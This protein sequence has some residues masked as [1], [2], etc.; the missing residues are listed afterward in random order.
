MT[1]LFAAAAQEGDGVNVLPIAVLLI[2][3]AVGWYLW[4]HKR[5]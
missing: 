5:R 3:I 2:A 1:H 4:R